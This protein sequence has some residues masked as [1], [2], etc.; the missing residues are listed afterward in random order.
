MGEKDIAEKIL[1]AYND[2]FSDIINVLLFGGQEIIRENDLEDQITG[3]AYKTD[4]K[5]HE[6]DRDV[7]K[8]WR[9]GNLRLACIGFEN[10]TSPDSDMPLRVI[11]YD[12]MEYRAQLLKR[13]GKESDKQDRYPVI[14]MVLY[15]GYEY[16]WNG[17]IS[18]KERLKIPDGLFR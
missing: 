17:P 11:A 10:Q 1:L 9:S 14:T 12:G 6:I 2:V 7:A 4:G 16:L 18:L 15:F 3:S 13:Q 8:R 5:L